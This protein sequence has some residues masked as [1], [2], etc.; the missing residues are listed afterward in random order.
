MGHS[1]ANKQSTHERIVG[2]AAERFCELG[3]EGLS[4][5]NLMKEAGLTHGGFYKHFESREQLVTEAL[6]SALQR[7]RAQ[8]RSY[9]AHFPALVSKYLSPE[10]RDNLSHGC[11]IGALISDIG[12]V[13]NQARTLYT[14]TLQ[15]NLNH[16]QSLLSDK[17]ATKRGEAIMAFSAMVG[18]LGLSRAVND[19]ALSDEILACV[20]TY[21]LEHFAPNAADEQA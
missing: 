6:N 16:L 1:Q 18:A 2:I 5:A 17:H 4:I 12:R 8:T 19:Q 3:I 15:S 9:Q 7:S 20:E 21:L 11:A 13:Q 14:Q 10:H